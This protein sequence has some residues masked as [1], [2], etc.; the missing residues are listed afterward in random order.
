MR[1]GDTPNNDVKG[2]TPINLK[3]NGLTDT[4]QRRERVNGSSMIWIAV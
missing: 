4:L 1:L 2:N 3:G